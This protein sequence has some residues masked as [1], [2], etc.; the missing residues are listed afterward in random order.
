LS[1]EDLLVFPQLTPFSKEEA[2]SLSLKET[3][4]VEETLLRP[5]PELMGPSPILKR[6][7]ES[8]ILLKYF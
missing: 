5:L 6:L 3:L 7:R 8:K 4:S 2:E 1:E